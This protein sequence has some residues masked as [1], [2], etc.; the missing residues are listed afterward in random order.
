VNRYLP[1]LLACVISVVF[2]SIGAQAGDAER[3]RIVAEVRCTPCHHLHLESIRIGPG[4]K[5]IYNRAP[6]MSGVPYAR[7]DAAAL[8]AWLKDPRGIKP[9]TKM[10]IPPIAQKDR[11][12]LI[13]YFMMEENNANL[14]KPAQQAE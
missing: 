5:G 13:A 9:N 7:W 14:D 6:R 10:A 1:N 2:F 12:D 4:L 8:D 3:G 11:E